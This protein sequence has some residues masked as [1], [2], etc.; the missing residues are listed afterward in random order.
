[1]SQLGKFPRAIIQLINKNEYDGFDPEDVEKIEFLSQTLGR[2]HDIITKV[3]QL[4]CMRSVSVGL[5]NCTIEVTNQMDD[6]LSNYK[7]IN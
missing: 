5:M 3:E 2:C 1:M 6:N 4:N 7:R